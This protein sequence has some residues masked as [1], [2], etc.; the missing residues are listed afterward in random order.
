[1][2]L[3]RGQ[4]LALRESQFV[5]AAYSIGTSTPRL[6]ARHI[7]PNVVSPLIVTMSFGLGAIALSEVVLSFFGLSVQVGRP[8]LGR[9]IGET[10]GRTGS[11]GYRLRPLSN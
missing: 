4:V 6:L 2:R 10:I 1:M 11:S 7:F 9:M 3:V 5:E 8:S